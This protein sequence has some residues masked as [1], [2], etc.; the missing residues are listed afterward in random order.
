MDVPVLPREGWTTL[1]NLLFATV[2]IYIRVI[3]CN[4]WN[5]KSLRVKVAK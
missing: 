3:N 5:F 2:I 4:E 1:I